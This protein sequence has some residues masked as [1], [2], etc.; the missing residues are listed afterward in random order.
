MLVLTQ[1]DVASA[2]DVP[3]LVD[4]VA[5]AMVDLSRGIASMPPR[6]AA[7][8]AEQ[9]G[10]LA[11]MPAYLPSAG[12][13]TAKLVSLFPR[14]Q[15]RATHQAII[16]C[17]DPA[18]GS[19]LALMDGTYITA[20]RTAAGSA[21]A[22][23]VLA[24]PGAT[25][26]AVLGTGVQ[27]RSHVA[28]LAATGR[29]TEVLLAGRRPAEVERLAAQ[30]SELHGVP[31]VPADSVRDAIARADVVCATTSTSVPIVT[32]DDVRDGTHINSVGFNSAGDGE[33]D[34][35]TIRDAVVVVESRDAALSPGSTGAT[36]IR[37]AIEA[38][39]ITAE[40]VHAELG[41]VVDGT[42]PGRTDDAQVT[43]YKSVGV[44]VQDAAAA[45][46]VLASARERGIGTELDL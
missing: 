45:A 8:V 34:A 35:E 17:F 44:A 36:D 33:V 37:R 30:L 46:H 12:A 43:L 3:A 21:V 7:M 26:V 40:H 25:T 23:Q 20:M 29:A 6:M 32:R 11:S 24:R 10:F 13:L 16:C 22:T 2:L 19:P 39:V 31:V 1:D 5:G 38:G 14:N 18:N 41:E 4:A 42:R 15:D 9:D 28:V 27:A